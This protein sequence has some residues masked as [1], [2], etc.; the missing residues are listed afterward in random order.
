MAI[1][2]VIDKEGHLVCRTVRG[3][4]SVDEIIANIEATL[5][6]PDYRPGMKDLTDLRE[7][8]HGASRED[9]A[10]LAQCIVGHNEAVTGMR[11]AL[12]VSTPVSYGMARMLQTH[13]D[14]L[15]SE[16][17]V[18]YDIEEAKRWLGID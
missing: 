8:A 1:D 5:Q 14:D 6:R 11:A 7:Y 3:A 15:P 4:V 13:L 9:I 2:V 18:F 17:A 12:V 10:R 16:I